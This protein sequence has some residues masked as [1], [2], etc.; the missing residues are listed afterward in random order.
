MYA[1]P[2]FFQK[3]NVSSD[4]GGG[5]TSFGDRLRMHTDNSM[6]NSENRKTERSNQTLP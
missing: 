2:T 4:I 1:R 3:R 6:A 5:L